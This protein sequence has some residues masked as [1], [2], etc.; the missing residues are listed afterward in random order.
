MRYFDA[1]REA[2]G[3]DLTGADEGR[4]RETAERLGIDL[5]G[6]AGIAQAVDEIFSET[7]QPNLVQPTFV[8]DF[9]LELSP[10]AKR[11]RDDPRLVE[12]FE[13]FAGGMELANAFSEQNDPA[14]QEAAFERQARLREEGD[15]EAQIT[16][17]D[18]L[19]ALQTGMP[20]TGGVGIGIDRLVM[21][22][23][24]AAN[25]RE[26][27]LFPQLRPEEGE[28]GDDGDGESAGGEGTA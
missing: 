8:T 27:I 11:H 3:V 2:V 24:G 20:P 7:A 28:A 6:K 25:I 1:I 13:L 26:V 9:P 12:R 15:L 17:T 4:V 5:K 23:T 21:V 19:R 18:Y 16:D 22:A 10:L 14:E